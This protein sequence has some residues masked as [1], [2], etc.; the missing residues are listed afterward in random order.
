[1]EVGFYDL[2]TSYVMELE[3]Y[4]MLY[5][6]MVWY[7]MLVHGMMLVSQGIVGGGMV[8]QYGMV[9]YNGMMLVCY[10]MLYQL[11]GFPELF[12]GYEMEV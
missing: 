12:T 1:M 5:V 7:G 9:C 3:W 11:V 8:C 6:S 4:G 10:G 2:F